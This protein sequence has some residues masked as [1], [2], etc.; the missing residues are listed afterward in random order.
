MPNGGPGHCG[1]CLYN[2]GNLGEFLCE[3]KWNSKP[4]FCSLRKAIIPDTGY[5]YCA[6]CKYDDYGDEIR[7]QQLSDVITG[8]TIKG[9]I[10]VDNN[11]QE[12]G[13][14]NIPYNDIKWDIVEWEKWSKFV[15]SQFPDLKNIQLFSNIDTEKMFWSSAPE[16]IPSNLLQ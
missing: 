1:G 16:R 8:E 6:N 10:W 7:R 14:D 11:Y 15:L 5:S 9:S 12:T 13:W 2:T 4:G 3:T